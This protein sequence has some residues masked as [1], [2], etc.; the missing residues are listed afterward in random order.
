M[1]KQIWTEPIKLGEFE[2]DEIIPLKEVKGYDGFK[3]SNCAW[4]FTLYGVNKRLETDEEYN[5]RLQ[6]ERLDTILEQGEEDLTLSI[7]GS[8][9]ETFNFAPTKEIIDLIKKELTNN[10][11]D[12][13]EGWTCTDPNNKQ[14]RGEWKDGRLYFKELNRKEYPS[15]LKNESFPNRV[16]WEIEELWIEDWI[17]PDNYSEQEVN[18]IL[19]TYGYEVDNWNGLSSLYQDGKEVYF[20]LELICEMI[21]EYES[22]IY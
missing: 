6:K 2:T 15:F 1:K 19:S 13:L 17:N 4:D 21:F 8:L 9:E 5:L 22:G 3:V 20:D 11:T 12:F 7:R 16:Q 10:S 14:Y 18:D